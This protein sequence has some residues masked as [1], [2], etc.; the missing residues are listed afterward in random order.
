MKIAK[1]EKKQN[2]VKLKKAEEDPL[3]ED[4]I[5]AG[6]PIGMACTK[7][8]SQQCTVTSAILLAKSSIML[9]CKL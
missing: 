7:F 4:G 2:I 1:K 9:L 8:V 6:R 5:R 3:P